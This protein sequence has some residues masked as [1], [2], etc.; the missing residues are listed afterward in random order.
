MNCSVLKK[1][2][3]QRQNEVST[4]FCNDMI[5]YDTM[6]YHIMIQ[7]CI[8]TWYN[9]LSCRIIKTQFVFFQLLNLEHKRDTLNS[10]WTMLT[11]WSPSSTI[12]KSQTFFIITYDIS[13]L[14]FCI[15]NIVILLMM[16]VGQFHLRMTH[17]NFRKQWFEI[18]QMTVLVSAAETI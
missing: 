17:S 5:L 18:P 7:Y 16:T 8:I 10:V 9:I 2:F 1:K 6:L 11:P 15:D 14:K 3:H 12:I 4:W 13:S